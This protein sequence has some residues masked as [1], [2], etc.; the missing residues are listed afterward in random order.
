MPLT[1]PTRDPFAL[2]NTTIDSSTGEFARNVF[3]TGTNGNPA[4]QQ[5]AFGE[6]SVAQFTPQTAWR[7]D[8]GVN[9]RIVAKTETNGGTVTQ[10]A[11]RAKLSTGTN[12]AG[13]ARIQTIK[14]VRYM[15]GVG[16]LLRITAVFATPKAD[17]TQYVGIGDTNDRLFFGY[18]GT[19]FV[20][21]RRRDGAADV[22]VKSTN[23]NGTAPTG[24][25]YTNGNIFQI[26]YQWLG[27]GYLRFYILDPNGQDLGY[28]LV[29]TINYPNTSANIHI[30]NPTL[31]IFAEI[32]NT[33][34]NTNMVMYSPSAVAGIEGATH[35][36]FH[37][38]LDIWN[39]TDTSATFSD[40]N[41]NHF[42]SVQNKTTIGSIANRVPVQIKSIELSRGSGGAA[43]A[44]I[45]IYKSATT[46]GAR[47]YTDVD[48][49][50]S[51]VS[52]STTTTTITGGT[53]E[54]SYSM[55]SS[56]TSR[57]IALEN[58]ELT[59][60]PGEIYTIGVQD[61]TAAGTD[62]IV[63]VNWQELF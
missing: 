42:I 19:D 51:P 20:I 38:P 15:P 16:G 49:T 8:Y 6:L 43:G 48:A 17:T 29:H 33:G 14:N 25:T 36:G 56:L 59:L 58:G 55:P 34:N 11:G 18:Q 28:K 7:F 54:R 40:T 24:L 46:A 10:D 35:L 62:F 44:T 61:S 13:L 4:F 41:N 9:T 52:Y 47:S 23:W 63:N 37:N 30:M 22:V 45:R 21:G 53:I 12:T 31:P 39:G 5:T 27:Y 57:T 1:T 3:L 32:A 26:R 50:N 2:G 60:L